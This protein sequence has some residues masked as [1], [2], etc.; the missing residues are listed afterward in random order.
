MY[1]EPQHGCAY[2]KSIYTKSRPDQNVK[3]IVV[4]ILQIMQNIRILLLSEK[5]LAESTATT[6]SL[7]TLAVL[8]VVRDSLAASS[9]LLGRRNRGS[10]GRGLLSRLLSRGLSRRLGTTAGAGIPDSG[11]GEGVVLVATP[12]AEVELWVV[13]LVGAGE[14]DGG[15]GGAA[16]AAGDLDLSASSMC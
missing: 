3:P 12:D 10:S 1:K 9:R 13:L 15:A 14:L 4:S 8:R 7:A 5:S 2:K 6:L 11:G 16:A